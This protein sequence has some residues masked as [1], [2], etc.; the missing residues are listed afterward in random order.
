MTSENLDG[1]GQHI[2][3]CEAGGCAYVYNIEVT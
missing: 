1:F 2:K 3:Q